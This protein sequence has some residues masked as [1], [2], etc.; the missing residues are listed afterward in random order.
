VGSRRKRYRAESKRERQPFSFPLYLSIARVLGFFHQRANLAH[1]D[2][3]GFQ[4][5]VLDSAGLAGTW[6]WLPGSG[7]LTNLRPTTIYF[8]FL[9]EHNLVSLR[10]E[11][12]YAEDIENEDVVVW[13]L[14]KR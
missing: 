10:V 4:L 8:L 11:A 14:G 6:I 1:L 5:L 13:L 2:F 12:V 9:A 3:Y 7:F